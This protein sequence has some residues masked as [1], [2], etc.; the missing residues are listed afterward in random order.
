MW[1]ASWSLSSQHIVW[2]TWTVVGLKLK[3]L[4]LRDIES[5]T[6]H[7]LSFGAKLADS[8]MNMVAYS[9]LLIAWFILPHP[10][11]KRP[12]KAHAKLQPYSCTRS[13]EHQV[14]AWPQSRRDFFHSGAD[15]DRLRPSLHWCTNEASEAEL[16]GQTT[17]GW[18]F[19]GNWPMASLLLW[20]WEEKSVSSRVDRKGTLGW[21]WG[22]PQLSSIVLSEPV[23][24][25]LRRSIQ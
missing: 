9:R 11:H 10:P 16:L 18:L 25:V 19:P 5:T 22:F 4:A 24:C 20:L 8:E 17:E 14:K 12:W 6:I 7:I 13:W 2:E 15:E 1:C 23:L 3:P 21:C